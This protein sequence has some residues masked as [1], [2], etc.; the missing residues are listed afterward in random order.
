[1]ESEG[2]KKCWVFLGVVGTIVSSLAFCGVRIV[3]C[4]FNLLYYVIWCTRPQHQNVLVREKEWEIE[5][6]RAISYY[7]I[8]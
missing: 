8:D 6:D 7:R 5:N 3:Q 4:L 2:G 1:M